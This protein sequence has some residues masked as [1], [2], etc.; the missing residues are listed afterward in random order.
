MEGLEKFLLYSTGFTLIVVAYKWLLRRL[1]K[2]DI[3]P[4]EFPYL[5][6]IERQFLSNIEEIK[7]EIPFG[8]NVTISLLNIKHE[9]VEKIADLDQNKGIY[10]FTLNTNLHPNGI[11]FILLA[12]P[13]QKIERRVE[14][15]NSIESIH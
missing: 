13:Q 9:M 15:K 2:N 4:D 11:Y 3:I 6:P 1:R 10:H 8:S 14:L 7:Y 5:F 12:T